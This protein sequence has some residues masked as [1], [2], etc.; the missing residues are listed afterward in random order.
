MRVEAPTRY[1][2]HVG[3]IYCTTWSKTTLVL[4]HKGMTMYPKTLGRLKSNEL[5]LIPRLAL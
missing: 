5:L 4:S 2:K 1:S 3:C